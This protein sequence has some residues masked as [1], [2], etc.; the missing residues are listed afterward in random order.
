[1]N[2]LLGE[3]GAGKSTLIKILTGAYFPDSGCIR[4]MGNPVEFKTPLE[5]QKQGINAVYQEFNLI[6][7]LSAYE[8]I[9]IARQYYKKR[10]IPHLDRAAMIQK[11]RDLINMLEVDFDVTLPVKDLSVAQRQIVEI[12]RALCWKS[13]ILIFDEPSAVLTGKEIDVLMKII[14]QLKKSG[15]GIIYISHRLEEVFQIGDTITVL[16]DGSLVG[17]IDLHVQKVEIDDIIKMMVGRSLDEKFPKIKF[18]QGDE[19][20]RV[21]N[22]SYKNR[23]QNVSF[24][25]FRG[26]VLGIAG[27][28]GAGRTEIAKSIFGE[29]PIESGRIYFERR[30]VNILNISDAISLGISLVPEDRQNEGLVLNMTIANNMMMVN[31]KAFT[32]YGVM[33][34]KKIQGIISSIAHKLRINT[35]E[36]TKTVRMLS[37]GNQQKVVLGKWLIANS[38]IVIL[39]EPT[40]G[41]DVGAKVEVYNLI[42]ELVKAGTGVIMISSELPEILGM[43]DRIIV[44]CEGKK[45]GELKREDAT[46][47]IILKYATGQEVAHAR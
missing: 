15:M 19:I 25:L 32:K 46:Q 1:V 33:I 47:E 5:S 37:G 39:D 21:E 4:I 35:T 45:T 34:P 8:N 6:P 44:M 11:S 20:L 36:Y 28:V 9:F 29:T 42:N 7:Q 30:P 43:S 16:R 27:L 31:R 40:R 38:R 3:N 24:S 17:E 26:E 18:E 41:V 22:I 10:P 12:A 23:F 13:K 14:R 2:V